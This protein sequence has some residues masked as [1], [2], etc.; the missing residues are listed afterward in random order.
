MNEDCDLK[1]HRGVLVIE[2]FAH[3]GGSIRLAEFV[4]KMR[5]ERIV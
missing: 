3:G 4:G 2:V 5:I 1:T